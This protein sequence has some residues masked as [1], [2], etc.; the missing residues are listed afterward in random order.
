[1]NYFESESKY[2]TEQIENVINKIA[3]EIFNN[4][5]EEKFVALILCS[6]KKQKIQESENNKINK[7]NYKRIYRCGSCINCKIPV[8]NECKNC[9]DKP[10]NGGKGRRKQLCLFKKE[11]FCLKKK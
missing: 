6:I 1:M 7:R 5:N 3:N 10:V 4:S 9:L 11:L 2:L 8:C